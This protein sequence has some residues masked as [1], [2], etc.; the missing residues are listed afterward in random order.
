MYMHKSEKTLSVIDSVAVNEIYLPERLHLS[1]LE[2]QRVADWNAT[3]QDYPR[4]LCI[5][6]LVTQQADA[7]PD[8]IALVAI[9]QKMSYKELNQRA[10]QLAHYLRR[11]GVRPNMPVGIC[12]ERSPDMVVGML[13]ILNAG[14]AYVPMDPSYPPERLTFMLEDAHITILLTHQHLKERFAAD[15]V[16]IVC[17]DRDTAILAQESTGDLPS[18]STITDLAYIIYTSGSTGRPKGAQITHDSLLNLVFWHQR[19]FNVTPS[20]RATQ[21]AS[22]AFDV[23]GCELWP[24]LTIGAS[25]HL[26]DESTRL[27]PTLL[28]DWLV[29]QHITI[30][31]LPTLLAENVMAL[32]WPSTSS[33]R[34]LLTGGDTLHHYPPPNLPFALINTYGLTE[35]TVIST[36]GHVLPTARTEIPPLIGRPIANTEI[37]ILNEHLQQVPIGQQGEL[38]IGGAGLAKGYLNRPE[39]TAE[40]FIPHPFSE[41]P[42]AQLYRTGDTAYYLP[43]GQIAFIGRSDQQVK[44]RG[45]R[46]ELGEIEAVLNQHPAVGQAVVVARED[47][48]G[49]KRLVAYIV[50]NALPTSPYLVSPTELR[51]FLQT[52]LPDYMIPATFQQME[53]LPLTLHG[54]VDRAALLATNE[55]TILRD[56]PLATF[57]TPIEEQLA[58]IIG[59]LL[60]LVQIGRDENFFMLGS[61]SLL[62]TQIIIRVTEIFGVELSLRAIFE[63]PTVAQLSA[64]IENL[65]IARLESMSDDEA[66]HLLTQTLYG[67]LPAEKQL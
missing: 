41:E 17:L 49:E 48:P 26:P 65:I 60:G 21:V 62:G 13:G 2:Q 35:T 18:L 16:H 7:T 54:K 56:T 45:Y 32:A 63:A 64:E 29:S 67:H 40:R 36:S 52:Q 20:D 19:A 34:L 44:I 50:I 28:R 8:A 4:D 31:C 14:G 6:Q 55:T 42:G 66:Q 23:T 15:N 51:S 12:I 11:L 58:A 10:N 37:Y 43:D 47:T 61:D 57:N 24:Y 1:E 33:L 22:P 39:L 46:I 9:D 27:I 38:C 30:T 5:P 59:S 3:Q 25:V 53:T